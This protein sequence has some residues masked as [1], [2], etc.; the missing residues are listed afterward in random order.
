MDIKYEIYIKSPNKNILLSSSSNFKEA[1][2]E[3]LP[4]TKAQTLLNKINET[5]IENKIEVPNIP[6]LELKEKEKVKLQKYKEYNELLKKIKKYHFFVRRPN[7]LILVGSGNTI[8]EAEENTLKTLEPIKEKLEGLE[9]IK[10]RLTNT[11]LKSKIFDIKMRDKEKKNLGTALERTHEGAGYDSVYYGYID[12][13]VFK[14]NKVFQYKKGKHGK[15]MGDKFIITSYFLKDN[16]IKKDP[17]KI[18]K[19]I[20]DIMNEYWDTELNRY[21]ETNYFKSSLFNVP[22]VMTEE[23]IKYFKEHKKYMPEY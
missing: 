19:Q 13:I 11:Y 4:K 3:A 6:E 21:D 5:K 2:K 10:L 20:K 9:L 17:E 8:K 23:E 14:N 22:K 18:M 16:S 7:K 12:N 15:Y 1:V